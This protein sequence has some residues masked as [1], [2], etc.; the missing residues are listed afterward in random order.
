MVKLGNIVFAEKRQNKCTE[1]MKGQQQKHRRVS[2]WN[3]AQWL[4]VARKGLETEI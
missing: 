4:N 2:C 3:K 1:K